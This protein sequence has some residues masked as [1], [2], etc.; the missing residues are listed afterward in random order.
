M[1]SGIASVA[2][3]STRSLHSHRCRSGSAARVRSACV[4]LLDTRTC[5]CRSTLHWHVRAE[6]FPVAIHVF[7]KLAADAGRNPADGADHDV[8]VGLGARRPKPREARRVRVS[9][10]HRTAR[11]LPAID[12]STRRGRHT[13]PPRRVH[14]VHRRR[15]GDVMP[16]CRSV[17]VPCGGLRRR[18]VVSFGARLEWRH[19][20]QRRCGAA[21][22]QP[23][24]RLPLCRVTVRQASMRAGRNRAGAR[25]GDVVVGGD[26]V[27]GGTGG[28]GEF[29]LPA[30]WN[31]AVSLGDQRWPLG[32]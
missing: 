7:R 21:G 1:A 6:F 22:A 9:S 3:C 5:G 26:S 17:R 29:E 2:R 25:R 23:A 15:C 31:E 28:V 14:V 30:H 19:R 18:S 12:E 24:A 20:V 13:R 10:K 11:R 8:R 32:S 27:R 16:Q 4:S